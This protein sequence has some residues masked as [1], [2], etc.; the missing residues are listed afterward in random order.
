MGP[1]H[2]Q[3]G[4][5]LFTG[6]R[7]ANASVLY[8]NL[9]INQTVDKFGAFQKSERNQNH[10]FC[11]TSASATLAANDCL[12]YHRAG[13]VSFAHLH[14]RLYV[15]RQLLRVAC[16]FGRDGRDQPSLGLS[17]LVDAARREVVRAGIRTSDMHICIYFPVPLLCFLLLLG[18]PDSMSGP[19]RVAHEPKVNRP[20]FPIG[21]SRGVDIRDGHILDG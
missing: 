20:L 19:G 3:S 17:C 14:R 8:T 21:L 6:E 2:S 1:K 12:R 15:Q 13:I 11:L 9:C 5:Q 16:G 10:F 7:R 4:S 18:L